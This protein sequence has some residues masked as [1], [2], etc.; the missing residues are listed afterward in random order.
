MSGIDIEKR[1]K[2]LQG[3]VGDKPTLEVGEFQNWATTRF[4]AKLIV[5][6]PETLEEVQAVVR[7]AKKLK[8]SVHADAT[9]QECSKIVL[10]T[11]T[12]PFVLTN[13]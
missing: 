11:N 13:R 6:E 5:C 3:E 1:L 2:L 8:V 9:V 4:I 7:A 12:R 10:H